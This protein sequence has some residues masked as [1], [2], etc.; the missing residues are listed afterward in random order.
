[1]TLRIV[2]F[3][4]QLFHCL[5]IGQSTLKSKSPF[6]VILGNI[7]DAGSPHMGCEKPCCNNLLRIRIQIE[8]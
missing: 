1:M 5:I 4:S 8:K 2:L 7:Q 6:V 3:F